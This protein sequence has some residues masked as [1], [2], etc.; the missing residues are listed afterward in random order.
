MNV[1]H[2][3][4]RAYNLPR[5]ELPIGITCASAV[6][7]ADPDGSMIRLCTANALGEIRRSAAEIG[8]TREV[9]LDAIGE[10]ARREVQQA[11]DRA[12][13]GPRP[14]PATVLDDVYRS[15]SLNA[16]TG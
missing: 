6:T 7:S 4:G 15:A 3:D 13:A 10:H 1:P 11:A 9:D 5:P 12:R 16:I 2:S 8:I 14:D